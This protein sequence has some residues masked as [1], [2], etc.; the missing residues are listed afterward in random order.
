M[1]EAIVHIPLKEI[2]SMKR[3]IELQKTRIF[4][5]EQK[6]DITIHIDIDLYNQSNH[7]RLHDFRSLTYGGHQIL[8]KEEITKDTWYQIQDSIKVIFQKMMDDSVEMNF[9]KKFPVWVK[10]LLK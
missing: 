6:K 5:L 10:E 2:E 4:E 9:Y 3:E 7:K 8:S 1:T